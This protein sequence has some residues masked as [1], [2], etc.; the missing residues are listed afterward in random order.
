M[1]SKFNNLIYSIMSTLNISQV[2]CIS[3]NISASI[4]YATKILVGNPDGLDLSS[5]DENT[6]IRLND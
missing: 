5:Y 3:H 1:R 6:L 2:I 4:N